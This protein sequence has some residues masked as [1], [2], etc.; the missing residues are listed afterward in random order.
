MI[1]QGLAQVTAAYQGMSAAKGQ[2]QTLP[3][4]VANNADQVTISAAGKVLAGQSVQQQIDAIKAKPGIERTPAD[5]E[6]LNKNDARFVELQGKAK[7]S[8]YESL[9]A[10]EVDYMQKAGGFVNT[11]AELSPQEKALYDELVA[12]GNHEAASALSLVGMSRIGMHGQQV[13]LPN[14]RAFDPTNTEVTANN[15]RNLFSQMFVDGSGQA[16]RQFEALA[17]YLDQRQV[18]EK[19]TRQA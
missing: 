9:R 2:R 7:D 11:M 1:I 10:D 12:Q 16:N 15:L 4:V 5:F 18:M 14:G 6:F 8:G 19:P 13:T 17:A 3:P